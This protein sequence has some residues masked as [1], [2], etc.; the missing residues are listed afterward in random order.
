M[1]EIERELVKKSFGRHA[2]QY[3]SLANVQ[4]KVTNRFT[5]LLSTGSTPPSALLDIGAGTGRLLEKVSRIFPD[6]D[7]VGVDLAFGMTKIARTR[8]EQISRASLEP[9]L[10]RQGRR[11][12]VDRSGCRTISDS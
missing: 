3:D 7:L 4:K 6:S 2:G 12:K 1:A 9:S 8:L 5:E 11:L 10:E